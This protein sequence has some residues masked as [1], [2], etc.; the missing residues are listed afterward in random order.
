[1]PS[2]LRRTV[3]LLM[4]LLL[5]SASLHAQEE[6]TFREPVLIWVDMTTLWEGVEGIE[7]A[8]E[9]TVEMMSEIEAAAVSLSE[10]IYEL[11][12]SISQHPVPQSWEK[13]RIRKITTG[14]TFLS[15]E[16]GK[17]QSAAHL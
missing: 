17:L 8:G 12:L 3:P 15:Q 16:L 14:I 10:L 6:Q 5:A 1:M 7:R 9:Y 4:P 13:A 2:L 11:Q